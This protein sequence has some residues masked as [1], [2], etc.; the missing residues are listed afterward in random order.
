M[1]LKFTDPAHLNV[2]KILEAAHRMIE[3][4]GMDND[5]M[6]KAET[7]YQKDIKKAHDLQDK[8]DEEYIKVKNFFDDEEIFR[9]Y[10]EFVVVP[11]IEAWLIIIQKIKPLTISTEYLENKYIIDDWRVLPELIP[12]QYGP[13]PK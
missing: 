3:A 6:Q 1:E 10:V 9:G 2:Q 13:N 5:T 12:K 11:W 4:A 7:Y 8:I